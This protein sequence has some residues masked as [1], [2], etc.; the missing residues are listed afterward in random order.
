MRILVS[1]ES[2]D[3]S[4]ANQWED[5][6]TL[7]LCSASSQL[8]LNFL[9]CLQQLKS[10]IS[11]VTFNVTFRNVRKQFITDLQKDEVKT[12]IAWHWLNFPLLGC[13]YFFRNSDHSGKLP[14]GGKSSLLAFGDQNS[15]LFICVPESFL[16]Y[17]LL[18]QMWYI[19]EFSQAHRKKPQY[20]TE[21]CTRGI[22]GLK[23]FV[24][25]QSFTS[26]N[27]CMTC[28]SELLNSS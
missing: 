5:L 24:W 28:C 6:V 19:C 27:C 22:A 7:Q 16:C 1:L 15:I 26:I 25:R 3:V 2:V 12:S 13:N 9:G 17:A 21:F 20:F 8:I 23:M 11:H 10:K 14:V 4:L 18:A